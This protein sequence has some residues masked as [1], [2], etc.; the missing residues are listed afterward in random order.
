MG[1]FTYEDVLGC[2]PPCLTFLKWIP[3]CIQSCRRQVA[4]N[5]SMDMEN[6]HLQFNGKTSSEDCACNDFGRLRQF[7]G[8][9]IQP[10]VTTDHI[11]SEAWPGS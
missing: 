10:S 11:E 5:C 9:T 8:E 7:A 6:Q 3:T 4:R 1:S 2:V